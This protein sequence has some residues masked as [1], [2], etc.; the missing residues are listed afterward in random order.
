MLMHS[1][2][3]LLT[4]SS[5]VSATIIRPPDIFLHNG[6]N[7]TFNYSDVSVTGNNLFGM[8]V[9]RSDAFVPPNVTSLGWDGPVILNIDDQDVILGTY[10]LQYPFFEENGSSY[11]AY[12]SNTTPRPSTS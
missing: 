6:Q 5:V 1:V 11:T 4:L 12:S 8:G 9:V 3:A 2:A 10:V 7:I